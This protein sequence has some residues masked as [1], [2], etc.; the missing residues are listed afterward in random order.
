MIHVLAKILFWAMFWGLGSLGLGVCFGDWAVWAGQ[1]GLGSLGFGLCLGVW[2][3][4]WAMFWGL[5]SPGSWWAA[6]GGPIL[7]FQPSPLSAVH[8][9]EHIVNILV[10][11]NIF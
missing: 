5:G 8:I 2:A 10:Y 4:F 9:F 6:L 7:H 1:S 11:F 3:M